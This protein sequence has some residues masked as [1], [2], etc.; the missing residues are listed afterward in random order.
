MARFLRTS[1]RLIL[2]S[3]HDLTIAAAY[4]CA[5]TKFGAPNGVVP[6]GYFWW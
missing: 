4:I 1:A 3:L 5:S 6:P 2:P